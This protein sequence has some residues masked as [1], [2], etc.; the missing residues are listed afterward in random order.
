MANDLSPVLRDVAR[1]QGLP[2]AHYT[3]PA[4]WTAE[5]DKLLW[6]QWAGIAFA[7][8]VPAP[9]DAWP[10]DFAGAPLLVLRDR[11]GAVRV[12]QNVCRHRGMI[13]VDAPGPIRGAIR[14]PYHS[15]CYGLDGRLVATPHVGGPG[16]NTHPDIDRAAG[17][18]R[19][20]RPC[21]ARRRLRQS[22]ATP[23]DFEEVHADL[24]ARWAEFEQPL[25]SMAAGRSSRWMWRPTGSSRSRITAKAITCPGCIRA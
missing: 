20:A 2:N 13:L 25:H 9:G 18:D 5:R 24:I 12:F 17:P 1:A 22:R 11:D 4:T 14:C 15:W 23:P 3:D 6:G 10:V 19:G 7:A 16:Q 21:L 8:D